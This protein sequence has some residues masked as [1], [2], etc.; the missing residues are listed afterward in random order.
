[1]MAIKLLNEM[2]QKRIL[3]ML[4]SK[5]DYV[6]IGIEEFTN[7]DT[8]TLNDLQALLDSCELWMNE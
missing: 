5:F 2:L 8:L 3:Y 4:S 6:V 1:M 7:L